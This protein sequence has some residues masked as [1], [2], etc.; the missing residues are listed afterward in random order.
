M[1]KRKY[2]QWAIYK[3]GV[4]NASPVFK[5]T[6]TQILKDLAHLMTYDKRTVYRVEFLGKR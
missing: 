4:N 5:G 1:S 3:C 6:K 2:D